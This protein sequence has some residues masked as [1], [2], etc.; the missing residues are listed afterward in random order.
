VSWDPVQ[1]AKFADHR[2]RPA[3]DLLARVPGDAPARVVDLGCGS[4]QVT[5]RLAER[6][7]AA[8]ITGVDSSREMLAAAP[9]GR[10]IEWREA[11]LGQWRADGP[12]DVLYS[13]AA[14]H[15]LGDHD[16]LFPH[17]L[18]QLGDG[19]VLAVQM[20]RNFSAPSHATAHEMALSPRWRARLGP[21]VRPVP[22]ADP[23]VYYDLLAPGA[24]RVDIWETEYLQALTGARPVLEWIK[25]TWLRPFL[26]ELTSEEGAEFEEEYARRVA[27]AYSPRAD[28]VTLLPFRRLFII[29]IR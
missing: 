22:V 9:T 19:G 28:G 2:L 6:W 24:T 18:G 1:Y 15:W 20:P 21:L 14:L 16:A 29:A 4:G 10:G 27:P 12:V 7:P 11:D 17:L 13:N 5:T 3:L 25:G 26:A 23:G 8:R